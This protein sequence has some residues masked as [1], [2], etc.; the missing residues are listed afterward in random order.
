MYELI[1]LSENN[2]YINC[3]AKIG[4]ITTGGGAAVIIDSGNNKEAGKRIKKILDAEGLTLK[5]IYNTHSH[6]DHIGGNRYL[7]LQTGCK[8]YASGI[9]RAWTA[10]PI[11][12]PA[13]LYGANPPEELRHKFLLAEES[14]CDYLTEECLPSG[15]S[16]IPLGGHTPDMVGFLTDEGIA[17]IGDCLSSEATLDKYKIGYIFDISEY[18][19][20][21]ERIK[22]MNAKIFVPSHAEPTDN[23]LPLAQLNIDRVIETGEKIT[24]LCL[25]PITFDE[26][27]AKVFSEYELVMTHEQHALVGST[28]RSYL[29]WLMSCGR[30][31]SEI[32]DNRLLWKK[33]QNE[34]KRLQNDSREA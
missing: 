18:L 5:A 3:P 1:K 23:I 14:E 9:E 12:E 21:L 16:I 27:L 24:E 17:Y 33:A 28:V 19:L 32:V 31:T 6:A 2:Y 13:L 15:I 4:I 22:A 34:N 10:H 8:I 20:T 7:Q 11:S 29:T 25:S 26:L 30:I